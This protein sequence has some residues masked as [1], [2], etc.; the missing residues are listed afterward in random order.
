[1]QL[2]AASLHDIWEKYLF[3]FD[4]SNCIGVQVAY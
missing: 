2:E 3:G 1:M 4:T